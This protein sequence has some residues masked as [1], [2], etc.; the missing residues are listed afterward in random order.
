MPA[1]SVYTFRGVVVSLPDT[2][3]R[4]STLM[5][6][7]EAIA[8]F[9]NELGKIV[10]MEEMTMPFFPKDLSLFQGILKGDEIECVVEIRWKGEPREVITSVKKL[11]PGTVHF[12]TPS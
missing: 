11:Q 6:H 3:R 8:E 2:E 1:D 12:Q 10:G 9:K 5:I 7:H 4:G